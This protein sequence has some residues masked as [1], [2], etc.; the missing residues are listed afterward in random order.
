MQKNEFY[1]INDLNESVLFPSKEVLKKYTVEDVANLVFLYFLT[2]Q[3]LKN[4][5]D[6][7][8]FAIDYLHKTFRTAELNSI[9][10]YATDLN[11]LLYALLSKNTALFKEHS[12][13]S[14]ELKKI[15]I[16]QYFIKMWVR[17][18]FKL[19]A[20]DDQDRRFFIVLEKM[21]NIRLSDYRSMRYFATNW[22]NITDDQRKLTIT[23]LVFALRKFSSRSEL[24]SVVNELIKKKHFFII[25]AE[26]PEKAGFL[27][28]DEMRNRI[29][30]ENC[31]TASGNIATAISPIIKE[32]KR[33]KLGNPRKKK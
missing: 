17:D 16:D 27:S 9:H 33:P 1:L 29:L 28:K 12:G 6:T 22:M 7:A 32:I 11:W 19:K 3:V 5:F 4:E 10:H 30:G 18:S 13:N 20:S 23:R 31:D 14:V 15:N 8:K 21:L 2:I 25:G 26:N 24:Y